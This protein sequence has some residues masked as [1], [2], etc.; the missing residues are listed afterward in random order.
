MPAGSRRASP[1]ADRIAANGNAIPIEKRDPR[2]IAH[3]FG[4]QTAPDGIDVYNRAL[5][6]TPARLITAIICERRLIRPVTREIMVKAA[7]TGQ[8]PVSAVS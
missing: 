8:R 4:R 1:R 7:A 3:G 2:E 6:V 5:D